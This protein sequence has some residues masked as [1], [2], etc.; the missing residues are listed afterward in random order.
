[1]TRRK[2]LDHYAIGPEMIFD[3]I[4]IKSLSVL[5]HLNI[6]GGFY[7]YSIFVHRFPVRSLS[8][9]AS[10]PVVVGVGR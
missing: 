2:T 10:R 7:I 8:R 1:V 3:I 4:G 6:Q 5:F 9:V